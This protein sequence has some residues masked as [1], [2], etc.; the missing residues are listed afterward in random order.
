MRKEGEP[1]GWAG[2]WPR[3]EHGGATRRRVDALLAGPLVAIRRGGG[4]RLDTLEVVADGV[5]RIEPLEAA[6]GEAD[7]A[8]PIP[9]A[10]AGARDRQ[11]DRR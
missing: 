1:T 8:V 9:V 11:H 3:G 10:G 2:N 4:D 7:D 6:A 5:C